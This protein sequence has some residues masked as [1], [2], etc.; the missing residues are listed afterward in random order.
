MKPHFRRR[1]LIASSSPRF[2]RYWRKNLLLIAGLLFIWF[3]VTFV[4]A[5]FAR[6]LTE[7]SVFGWPFPFWMAAFGAPLTY[8]FV[9]WFYAWRMDHLDD[10]ARSAGLDE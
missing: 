9:I 3:L 1:P 5:F 4:P 2:G 6:D 7:F 8:L 10:E